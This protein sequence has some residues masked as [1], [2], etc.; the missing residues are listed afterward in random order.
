MLYI[1]IHTHTH[2]HDKNNSYVECS[3]TWHEVSFYTHICPKTNCI[4]Y[5]NDKAALHCYSRYTP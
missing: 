2:T 4:L 3:Y 1:Y 5:G